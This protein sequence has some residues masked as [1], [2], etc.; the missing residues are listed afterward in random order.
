MLILNQTQFLQDVD[1][2]HAAQMYP[3]LEEMPTFITRHRESAAERSFSTTAEPQRLRGRQL[4]AYTIIQA[5]AEAEIPPPLR[6]IVSGTA[7]TGK[8][9][10][11]HCLRLLLNNRVQVAAPTGV[12]AFS[13]EGHILH[14][15]LHLPVKGEFKDLEGERLRQMQ[16]FLINMEYLIIDEMSMVGRKFLGQV[17]K[18]LR[19]VFPHHADVFVVWKQ[20]MLT[21]W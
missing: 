8:S 4:Q 21:L 12:A 5:H 18:R 11:I 15:L 16:Q 2:T 1:W 9:H 6:M 10:L 19:Q 14:S 20:L 7:G 13:I 17:D 3:D